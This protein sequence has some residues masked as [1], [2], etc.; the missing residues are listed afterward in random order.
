MIVWQALEHAGY[1]AGTDYQMRGVYGVDDWSNVLEWLHSD[2]YPTEA[3]ALAWWGQFEANAITAAALVSAQSGLKDKTSLALTYK[4]EIKTLWNVCLDQLETNVSHPTRFNN[5]LA[6]VNALPTALK[7]RVNKG[8]PDPANASTD[9]LKDVYL[10][11]VL[12]IA[13]NLAMLLSFA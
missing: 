11:H 4:T 12:L 1:K 5:V 3:Q 9:A 13:G 8:T 6:A 2:P 10:D 7:N